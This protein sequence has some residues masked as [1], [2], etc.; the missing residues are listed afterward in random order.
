MK[1][2]EQITVEEVNEETINIIKE[3]DNGFNSGKIPIN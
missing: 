1:Y 2:K 3:W